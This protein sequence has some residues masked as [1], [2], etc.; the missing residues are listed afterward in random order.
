MTAIFI[1]DGDAVDYTP[2]ADVA[3]GDVVVQEELVGIAKRP[4][5]TGKLGALHV[6]GVF[7]FPKTPGVGEAIDA[8]KLVYWDAG[9]GVATETVGANKLIGKTVLAATDDDTTVRARLDQ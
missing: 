2:G 5:L 8:G 1:H 9:G 3:P 6:K 7:D 4:I